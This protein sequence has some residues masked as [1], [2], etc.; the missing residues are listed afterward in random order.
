MN[1]ITKYDKIKIA[2]TKGVKKGGKMDKR[3][4]ITIGVGV[5]ILVILGIYV[6]NANKPKLKTVTL[7]T[8]SKRFSAIYNSYGKYSSK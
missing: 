5:F 1:I 6:F 2:K 7:T 3:K 4:F 8:V